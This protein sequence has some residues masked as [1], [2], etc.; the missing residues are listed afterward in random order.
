LSERAPVEKLPK[1]PPEWYLDR[2]ILDLGSYFEAIS[3]SRTKRA[4]E[5]RQ[6][7]LIARLL[8]DFEL[9]TQEF[10]NAKDEAEEQEQ[11]RERIVK[12]AEDIPAKIWKE[13]IQRV[14]EGLL[15]PANKE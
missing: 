11:A 1:K 10:S 14:K 3:P 7:R 12:R 4:E 5:R 8:Y 15:K 6:Y 2:A 13:H 9:F